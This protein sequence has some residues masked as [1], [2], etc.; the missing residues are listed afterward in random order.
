MPDLTDR[1][2]AAA[3]EPVSMTSDGNSAT[4]RSIREI[5]E[6][7]EYLKTNEAVSSAKR[8]IVLQRFKPPGST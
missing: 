6:A 2:E 4:Q 8:G 7:D 1:I 5:I 3:S